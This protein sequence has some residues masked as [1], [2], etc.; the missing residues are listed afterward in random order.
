MILKIK[1]LANKFAFGRAMIALYHHE[2]HMR[3]RVEVRVRR[4]KQQQAKKS[5]YRRVSRLFKQTEGALK[6]SKE[7]IRVAFFVVYDSTFPAREVLEIMLSD[8]RFKPFVAAIPDVHRGKE[9]ELLQLKK[10]YDSLLRSYAGR[11]EVVCPY[12]EVNNSYYD[13]TGRFDLMCSAN[14]YFE[15]THYYYT[16]EY[17]AEKGKLPFLLSYGYQVSRH[18]LNAILNAMSANTCWKVFLDTRQMQE[19]ASRLMANKAQNVVLA[20][21]GK[22]DRMASITKVKRTRRRIILAP[23]HTIN[24]N[25]LPMSNFLNYADFLLRLPT[26]YPMIDFV[27]RP[28]PLLRVTLE[29]EA[30][31][32]K[33]KTDN[34]FFDMSQ[35]PNVTYQNGGDYFDVFVNSDALIHDCGSFAAEYLFTGH[36]ACFVLKDKSFPKTFF[37]R[38]MNACLAHHYLAFSQEDIIAFIDKVVLSDVD[39]KKEA[40]IQFAEESLMLNYPQASARIV[41]DILKTLGK[42]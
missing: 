13:L 24:F 34:Y 42:S 25:A 33:E 28:H 29:N 8:S 30:Q 16:V 15:M 20:G 1:E 39:P 41:E 19:D 32:G 26:L 40:R 3:R 6:I 21:Y 31:W 11:C 5:A 38:L 7:P 27:F 10:T 35:R 36:P 4:F 22:M 37:N 23:H 12:D 14:P 17:A 9:N 2:Q 18:S